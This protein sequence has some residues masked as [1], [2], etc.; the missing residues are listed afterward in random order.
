MGIAHA[1]LYTSMLESRRRSCLDGSHE[2]RGADCLVK[3]QRVSSE[4]VWVDTDECAG[5]KYFIKEDS[6]M[7]KTLNT[8]AF[9]ALNLQE[10]L[11]VEGGCD[12]CKKAELGIIGRILYHLGIINIAF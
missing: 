2:R 7:K 5:Y 6:A 10:M 4:S 8:E 3:G 12:T 1:E 11:A 9:E